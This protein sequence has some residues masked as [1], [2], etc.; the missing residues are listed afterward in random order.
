MARKKEMLTKE[1]ATREVLSIVNR[2]ALLH[3]SYAKTLIRE[4]GAKKGKEVTRK[5]IDFYGRQVGKQVREK[6][7]A[8][9]LETFL[10]NYQEDLPLLGWNMEKVVVDGEPRVRIYDCNLAKAWNALG[11]PT[12]GR[13]YCYMDQAK[14][15]AYNSKLECVHIKNTLDGDPCCEL[16]IRRKKPGGSRKKG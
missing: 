11:D 14:Y 16:A 13:L 2:M 12:L 15:T 7:R 5:A 10:E 6:T 9:G 4:L 8:K 3:Y 1:D